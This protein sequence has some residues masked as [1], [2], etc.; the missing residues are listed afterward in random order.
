[1][2]REKKTYVWA[3]SSRATGG[4]EVAHPLTAGRKP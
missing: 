3:G 2:K 1:M 4:F